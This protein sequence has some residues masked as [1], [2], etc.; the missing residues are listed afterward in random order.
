[1]DKS[2]DNRYIK[3]GVSSDKTDVH[4]AIKNIDNCIKVEGG[5]HEMII[6]RAKWFNENLEKI[7]SMS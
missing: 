2:L 4:K 1:M 7:I 5:N 6:T 3:R